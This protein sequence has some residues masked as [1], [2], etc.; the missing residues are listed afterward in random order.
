MPP[1]CTEG[2]HNAP[3]EAL[4]YIQR[5]GEL[6]SVLSCLMRGWD[7][8]PDSERLNVV[9]SVQRCLIDMSALN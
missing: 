3:P 7:Q 1:I 2:A 6:S 4:P 5:A 8:M 9:R